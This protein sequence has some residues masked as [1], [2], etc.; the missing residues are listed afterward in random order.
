MRYPRDTYAWLGRDIAIGI[1]IAIALLTAGCAQWNPSTTATHLAATPA[2]STIIAKAADDVIQLGLN[3]AATRID[4]GNPYLHSI[5][6]AIRANPEGIIDPVDVQKIFTDYGDP[7]NPHKFKLLA[8]DVWILAKNAA[9][10]FGKANA[11]EL[12]ATGLQ[13]GAVSDARTAP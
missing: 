5:A 8:H 9:V 3:A 12:L 4:T 10:R 1:G 2:G 13:A 6:D 11:A 7:V